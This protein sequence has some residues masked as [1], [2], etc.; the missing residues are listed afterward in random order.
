MNLRL[1]P[2]TLKSSRNLRISNL[3]PVTSSEEQIQ[4]T[5]RNCGVIMFT[6]NVNASRP[7]RSDAMVV[8]IAASVNI[9][10]RLANRWEW[11]CPQT[12]KTACH[13]RRIAA[14]A[15]KLTSFTLMEKNSESVMPPP[16]S[17]RSR[18]LEMP[19]ATTMSPR[20]NTL[21]KPRNR[22]RLVVFTVPSSGKKGNQ[23]GL[24]TRKIAK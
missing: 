17:R 21:S 15:R 18:A 22:R 9:T 7:R 3:A 16:S 20:L 10:R 8:A 4:N 5:S 6:W 24:P 13:I 1:C 2:R 11:Y 23:S 12:E 19:K 14:K